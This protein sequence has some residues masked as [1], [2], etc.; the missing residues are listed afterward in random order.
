MT[1]PR[2]L[3][4]ARSRSARVKGPMASGQASEV[5]CRKRVLNRHPGVINKCT[6]TLFTFLLLP[7]HF[8]RTGSFLIQYWKFS[9]SLPRKGDTF[10]RRVKSIGKV[11]VASERFILAILSFKKLIIDAKPWQRGKIMIIS[12]SCC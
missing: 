2:T 12:S 8:I 11:E 3:V 6:Q 7:Y 9:G 10:V 4:S 1:V 5:W